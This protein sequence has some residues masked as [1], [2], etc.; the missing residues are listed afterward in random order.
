MVGDVGAV[1]GSPVGAADGSSV[2]AAVGLTTTGQTPPVVG[3]MTPLIAPNAFQCFPIAS[4]CAFQW[5]Q[6]P[7][8]SKLR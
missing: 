1:V 5:A 8:E 6:L 3:V 2:G 4:P 7:S